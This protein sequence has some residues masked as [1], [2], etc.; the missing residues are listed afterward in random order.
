MFSSLPRTC[1]GVYLSNLQSLMFLRDVE[2][3]KEIIDK[4]LLHS[5]THCIL[6][7]VVGSKTVN[8]LKKLGFKKIGEYESFSHERKVHIMM[9]KATRREYTD[10]A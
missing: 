10:A 8:F 3:S 9:R 7:C 4:K 2:K 6:S 5:R 1:T